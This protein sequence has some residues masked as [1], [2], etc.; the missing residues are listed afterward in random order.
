M[1]VSPGHVAAWQSNADAN[2]ETIIRFR[3][4]IKAGRAEE[5]FQQATYLTPDL[6]V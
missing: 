5:L 4:W 2:A 1:A 6:A 3:A